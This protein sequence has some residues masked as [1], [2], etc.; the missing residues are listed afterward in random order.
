MK[1]HPSQITDRPT[2]A[3]GTTRVR[4]GYVALTDCAPVV[5]ASVLGMDRRHGVEF[6]LSRE[7]SWAQLRDK[8]IGGELEFAHVLYGLIYG[9]HLGIGG[10]H[11]AMAALMTLDNNGQGFTLSRQLVE[12]GALDLQSLAALMR[13]EPRRY[14]FAQTFPTGTHA[15]W[16]YYWLAAAGIHPLRDTGIITV[17][18]PQMVVHLQRGLMDGFSV[19]E[20]WNH[21]AVIDGV[22]ITADASQHVWPDHPEK[23]LGTTAAYADAHPDT[24][25]AATMAVLE[26]CRWIDANDA[27]RRTMAETLSQPAFLDTPVDS[28]LP[29]VMGDYE[30]G[31]RR[32]QRD[33]H[34]MRFFADGAVNFPYLSDGMWFMTQYRRWGMLAEHPDYA[35]IA[36]RINRTDLYAEA[37]SALGV[38]VPASPL[39]SSRLIDG[40]VWDGSDPAAY[41][42]AFPIGADAHAAAA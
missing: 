4:M 36:R 30:F 26:A 27:N 40:V 29:R 2:A 42:D 8:L 5:M 24:C 38:A 31:G 23:V 19:G 39:R 22:G 37:A 18:P 9:V 32:R 41:A 14:T 34:P 20:P 35:G 7:N 1:T 17:P 11:C 33:P 13:R 15:M 12:R 28:I 10:P 21:R 25:R 3:P 16:L 6:V